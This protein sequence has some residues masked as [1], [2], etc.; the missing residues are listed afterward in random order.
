MFI[1]QKDT[2][3]HD[4]HEKMWSKSVRDVQYE[5][6]NSSNAATEEQIYF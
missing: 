2:V 1:Y 5:L 6:E 4:E 3:N